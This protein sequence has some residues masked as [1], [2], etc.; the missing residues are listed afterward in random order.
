MTGSKDTKALMAAM[1]R[2]QSSMAMP[3]KNTVNTFFKSKYAT[4]GSVLEVIRQP[5]IDAGL[6]IVQSV[7]FDTGSHKKHPS[8]EETI[9]DG[10]GDV[11]TTNIHHPE[12]GEWISETCKL[13]LE[14][15]TPQGVG[16][17]T[18]YAKRQAIMAMCQLS[19]EDDDGEGAE[20]RGRTPSDTPRPTP[21]APTKPQPASKP[22]PSLD[23]VLKKF[24]TA[25]D[26]LTLNKLIDEFAPFMK[27]CDAQSKKKAHDAILKRREVLKEQVI[28]KLQEPHE[29]AN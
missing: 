27:T 10:M 25:K 19:A 21:T 6:V 4:L 2:A 12:S 28:A 9:L 13:L 26:N 14:K 11:L 3:K 15:N 5:L 22:S 18:T 17:A 7:G 16:S 29:G 20:Q 1:L 8:G 24:T 23:S